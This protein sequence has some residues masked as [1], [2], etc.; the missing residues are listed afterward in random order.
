M[1]T[2]V[3]PEYMF[4]DAAPTWSVKYLW[5][6]VRCLIDSHEI[7][8]RRAFELGCG[9]GAAA[10][11]L[12]ERG[13]QVTA[14][15]PSQ[16]NINLAKGAY[17]QCSFVCAGGYDDLARR[18]GTFGVVL[19]LEVLQH[20]AYPQRIA[21]TLFDL[22][23]PGGFAIVSVTYHGYLK[24]LL[25][26]MTGRLDRHL[27]ALWETGPLKFFSKRTLRTL[28]EEAGFRRVEFQLVG[29]VPPLAKSMVAIAYK[30]LPTG[31]TVTS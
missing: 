20:C 3:D 27:H 23:E 4:Y 31:N 25:L 28:L 29:R 17:P 6:S 8:T 12:H 10:N 5:P 1:R 11:L 9:N 22:V 13:F 2:T 14:V 16:T 24:N 7:R 21:Q 15:D 18:F 26:A 19:S 30:E